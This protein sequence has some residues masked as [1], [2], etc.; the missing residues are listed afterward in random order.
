MTILL[1]LAS[2]CML[3]LFL[4]FHTAAVPPTDTTTTSSD[5]KGEYYS[6][7]HISFTE[8]SIN[9]KPIG[10]QIIH[11]QRKCMHACAHTHTASIS[12][13]IGLSNN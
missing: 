4:P 12:V 10:I 9:T 2:Y 11:V 8:W 6:L 7:T 1:T 5:R 13:L 3:T